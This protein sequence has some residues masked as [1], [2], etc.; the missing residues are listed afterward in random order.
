VSYLQQILKWAQ[1]TLQATGNHVGDPLDSRSNRSQHVDPSHIIS[2][3]KPAM[4]MHFYMVQSSNPHTYSEVVCNPLWEATMK[5][6]N[7]SLLENQTWDMVPLP[8][9]RKRFR[10]K[11]VYRTK[12]ETYGQVS[13]Y[14]ALL[15]AKG[16]QWIHGIDYDDTFSPVENMNSIHLD[17]A[18]AVAKEW[19][20]HQMDVKN[21]F[22][23][24]ERS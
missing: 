21:A 20:V 9:R 5:E 6:E 14:K 15:V 12:R 23:H 11:W 24:G 1:S 18:I 4:S 17:L 3:S 7:D 16:F 10:C 8:P 2:S 19:E 13:R 22:L